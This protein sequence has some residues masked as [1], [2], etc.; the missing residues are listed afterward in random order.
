M[1]K[2]IKYTGLYCVRCGRRQEEQDA[3]GPCVTPKCGS[4]GFTSSLRLVPWEALMKLPGNRKFLRDMRI[5]T[6]SK[7]DEPSE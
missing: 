2:P 1:M 7:P 6:G 3:N 5:G 4:G